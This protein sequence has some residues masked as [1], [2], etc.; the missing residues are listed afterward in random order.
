MEQSLKNN[1]LACADAF[2]AKRKVRLTTLGRMVANDSP[3]FARLR[4]DNK[5]S[6]T[7]RKYD[8]IMRWFSDHWPAGADWPRSVPRPLNAAS[9]SSRDSTAAHGAEPSQHPTS[10]NSQ[11]QQP[12]SGHPDAVGASSRDR[13]FSSLHSHSVDAPSGAKAS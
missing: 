5:S 11:P 10:E 3:F 9:I 13:G 7:A 1:L 8:E 12:G 6:F 4:E 2:V